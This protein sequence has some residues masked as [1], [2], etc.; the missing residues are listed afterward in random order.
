MPLTI[1][2]ATR[3]T[4]PCTVLE[5]AFA[6]F[7]E[8]I[9]PKLQDELIDEAKQLAACKAGGL[10]RKKRAHAIVSAAINVLCQPD[11]VGTGIKRLAGLRG[12]AAYAHALLTEGREIDATSVAAEVLAEVVGYRQGAEDGQRALWR[13]A[14]EH[15]GALRRIE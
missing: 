3:P 2:G 12:T 5:T 13:E 15:L 4:C 10:L 8:L 9:P 14:I 11:I 7:E 6:K 1:P